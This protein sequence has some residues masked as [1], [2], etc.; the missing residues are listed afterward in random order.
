MILTGDDCDDEDNCAPL[1]NPAQTDDIE[2]FGVGDVCNVVFVKEDAAGAVDASNVTLH[3]LVIRDNYGTVVN[4]NGAGAHIV[5]GSVTVTD[6]LITGNYGWHGA[7]MAFENTT[8]VVDNVTFEGNMSRSANGGGGLRAYQSSTTISNSRFLDN[9]AIGGNGGGLHLHQGG[10][11]V[12]NSL[13]DGNIGVSAA[14]YTRSSTHDFFNLTVVNSIPPTS[15][16]TAAVRSAPEAVASFV[17][18]L[19]WNNSGGDI[20]TT[21][22][23]QPASMGHTCSAEDLS[24]YVGGDNIQLDSSTT[25]LSSPFSDAA[26][27]PYHLSNT[28]AG[29]TYT[30]ACVDAGETV[31]LDP[32]TYFPGWS[33]TTTRSDGAADTAPIDVGYHY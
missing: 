8:G 2:P 5:R 31:D 9:E 4:T 7:G 32:D 16:D 11:T 26:V 22:T 20:S 14:I 21:L 33:S 30:S 10:A 19:F 24:G 18:T 29:D 12:V 27:E 28:A 15:G 13:F 25:E 3:A 17:N 6:S 23:S 1:Y